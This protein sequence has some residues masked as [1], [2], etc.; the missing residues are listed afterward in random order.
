MS[1][2]NVSDDKCVGES[3]RTS[4]G[5]WF[6]INWYY[7]HYH[8]I[9]GIKIGFK[10]GVLVRKSDNLHPYRVGSIDKGLYLDAVSAIN[11]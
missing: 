9:F 11:R 4:F 6:I 5:E 3:G 1:Y 2:I 8:V 7:H 10:M